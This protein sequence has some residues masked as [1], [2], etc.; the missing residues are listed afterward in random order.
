MALREAKGRRLSADPSQ[1]ASPEV[2]ERPGA[3]LR[4]VLVCD[5]ADSTALVGRLGDRAAADLIG[6]HDRLARGIL[7]RHGGRE[8]DKTDGFLILFE[9][10]IEA[11]AFALEYQRELHALAEDVGEPLAARVGIH[12]GEVM[13]WSNASADI[14]R[15]AKP[16]EV[17]GLAKPVAARL[18]ALAVPGQILLSGV[19]Y[20]LAQ[21]GE[22]ELARTPDAV[23]W[24][25]HGRYHLKGVFEPITVFEV[26]DSD[27]APMRH[28]PDS[29]KAWRAGRFWRNPWAVA[30]TTATI[31]A[32]AAIPAY[33]ALHSQPAIGFNE[34]DWVVLG[35]V[36]NVN[37]DQRFD[38][39]FGSAFRLGL[40][41]SQ[42]VN[43]VPDIQVR[44]A[45]ELMQRS[46]TTTVDRQLAAEIAVREQARAVIVPS[47]TQYGRVLRLSAEIV[48][49]QRG[50]TVSV[51]T[52]DADGPDNALPAMDRLLRDLRSTLGESL[53]Q[54]QST[55]QP[56]EQVSTPNLEALRAYSRA[57]QLARQGDFE[58]AGA[59]LTH[60]TELDPQFAAA[61]AYMGSV[62]YSQERWTEARAALEKALSFE[63]R[64]TERTRLYS[65]ALLAHF[66]DP[67]AALGL[68]RTHANLFPDIS[69]GQQNIGNVCYLFLQDYA[70]AEAGFRKAA[71]VRNP[72]LNY[73]L[74]T[75]GDV[76]VADD[77]LDDAV[78][79]YRAAHALS[80]A[81]GLFGLASALVAAGKLEDAGRYLDETVQQPANIEVER[82]MRRAT[83][84][85][86][87]GQIDA[88]ASAV[89]NAMN[90][91]TRLQSPNP[92]WRARAALIALHVAR[93]DR[94]SARQLAA[95]HLAE[96]TSAVMKQ[97]FGIGSV[98]E[99]LYAA[100]WGAR[101]GLVS[102]AR[103]A[104]RLARQVGGL[105]RFPVRSQLAL[106]AENE[107]NLAT[108]AAGV[109]NRLESLNK[110]AGLWE[111]HELR[112]RAFGALGDMPHEV[113]ELRW[114]QA[115]PGRAQTQWTDQWLGQQARQLALR[116][117]T[118]RLV[119]Y[120]TTR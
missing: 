49:P 34:R 89:A 103:E 74:D 65:R 98:E 99:L 6:R 84:L 113:D 108:D 70:C 91:A 40:E 86:A 8:I 22:Q 120:G 80:P 31:L 12:V 35:D 33:L 73:T 63:G 116:D 79:Q 36:V 29:P 17:E 37:A 77:R 68:W 43:V 111:L 38:A 15:G 11:I 5:L 41:Q 105:D 60:A 119:A 72:L 51:Q 47:V 107:L 19:A 30:A 2:G 27:S 96:L 20:A 78:D 9:R 95:Q 21:R 100:A 1:I 39:V 76:L 93:N 16:I 87:G 10:P 32:A 82:D 56:L 109:A 85:V 97:D 46:P 23:R 66:S 75:L 26:G 55:T 25:A 102:P 106:L 58:Q 112:A 110:E 114:M 67:R 48:D 45:L 52:S 3:L 83:L 61:Y 69:T 13:V 94:A 7:Q 44:Q 14:A 104:L 115:H 71:L 81:P 50:R 18:M 57:L 62:L 54:I 92:R 117:A 4:T 59:A 42:F 64:L 118:Q 88:A 24:L 28:P 101:I 90:S 53:A